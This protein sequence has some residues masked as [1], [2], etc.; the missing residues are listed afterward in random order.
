MR[1]YLLKGIQNERKRHRNVQDL[2][3]EG[4]SQEDPRKSKGA[5]RSNHCRYGSG[6]RSHRSERDVPASIHRGSDWRYGRR[7]L[8]RHERQSNKL[9]IKSESP[10]K[11]SSFFLA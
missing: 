2:L 1:P 6:F 3:L 5:D 8:Q 11:G 9:R 10:N 7:C 4:P